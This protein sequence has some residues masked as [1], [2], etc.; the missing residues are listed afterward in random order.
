MSCQRHAVTVSR[1]T[2]P[3]SIGKRLKERR[4]EKKLTVAQVADGCGMGHSTLYDIERG[5][6]PSTTK[7]HLLCAFLGLNPLWVEFKRPPR[8]IADLSPAKESRKV[9]EPRTG[10]T[11]HGMQTTSEEVEFGIEWGKLDEPARSLVRQQVMLLVAEQVRA[12]RRKAKDSSASRDSEGQ[13]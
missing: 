8:L 1:D 4:L 3:M 9:Q 13:E 5:D 10:Y 11:L 12:K 7:L 6:Q 2:A